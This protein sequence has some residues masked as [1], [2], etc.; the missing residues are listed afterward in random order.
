MA[1]TNYIKHLNNVYVKFAE[2]ENLNTSHISLYLA[3]FQF[4]NMNRFTNPFYINRNEVMKVSKIGSKNTYHKCLR[5]L[6]KWKY[7]EY[8]PSNNP[9]KSSQINLPNLTENQCP[10]NG[11]SSVQALYPFGTKIGTSIGISNKHYKQINNSKQETK[12]FDFLK[13][14]SS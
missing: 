4:W 14:K 10:K 5:E 9:F 6:D 1:E 8:L 7:I 11:T 2:D 3:L 12:D 13:V